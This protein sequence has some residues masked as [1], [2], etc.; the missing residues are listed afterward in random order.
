MHPSVFCL[1]ALTL[2]CTF[3]PPVV[4]AGDGGCGMGA[5]TKL[6]ICLGIG[7]DC[8]KLKDHCKEIKS[9]R[10]RA[11][12]YCNT[13]Q[14]AANCWKQGTCCTEW[15]AHEA[16][17]KAVCKISKAKH[18]NQKALNK[19]IKVAQA[20]VDQVC[21]NNCGYDIPCLDNE[22]APQ[23]PGGGNCQPR[24][25]WSNGKCTGRHYC[26]GTRLRRD[27]LGSEI[28]WEWALKTHSIRKSV[29]F[30]RIA[31]AGYTCI[32]YGFDRSRE[33]LSTSQIC[34]KTLL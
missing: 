2:L 11:K 28:S 15:P 32:E 6:A 4:L 33:C 25:Y 21:H 18:I 10:S 5:G 17:A 1:M 24:S 31:S 20:V 13:Y 8:S 26:S 3:L 34:Q 30:D 9:T 27:V 22:P 14:H 12:C 16:A 23:Q 29:I 7:N 19:A